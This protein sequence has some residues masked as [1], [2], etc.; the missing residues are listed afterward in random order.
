MSEDLIHTPL[1]I[2]IYEQLTA[3]PIARTCHDALAEAPQRST[4]A[5]PL[6]QFKCLIVALLA[7]ATRMNHP[8]EFW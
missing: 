2:A 5:I 1:Q 8:K 3:E 7:A 6:V 4:L